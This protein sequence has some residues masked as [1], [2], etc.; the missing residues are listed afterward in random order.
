MTID[1][2]IIPTGPGYIEEPLYVSSCDCPPETAKVFDNEVE[3]LY[4]CQVP[5]CYEGDY[6]FTASTC[7]DQG[8][9][10]IE[11]CGIPLTATM[12]I[13]D[14]QNCDFI[15][16][17][18]V[19]LLEEAQANGQSVGLGPPTRPDPSDNTGELGC[20][21]ILL[22][23]GDQ[24][25]YAAIDFAKMGTPDLIIPPCSGALISDPCTCDSPYNEV[26][27]IFTDNLVIGA[28]PPGET[29]IIEDGSLDQTGFRDCAT[30]EPISGQIVLTDDDMDGIIEYEFCRRT[31]EVANIITIIEDAVLLPDP[32]NAG[33]IIMQDLT[34]PFVSPE[35]CPVFEDCDQEVRPIPTMG[36]WGLLCL[37]FLMMIF[38]I[39]AIREKNL[40]PART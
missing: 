40:I 18:F 8:E 38:G 21:D 33:Q 34:I 29:V 10:T 2:G 7:N 20:F 16:A 27:E 9:L 32:V 17:S 39:V 25:A 36:E 3:G 37:G 22:V 24:N 5:L 19:E 1:F 35:A 23:V 26:L 13:A 6:T 14:L 11:I 12:Q 28:L 31:G 4:R 15:D 30:G